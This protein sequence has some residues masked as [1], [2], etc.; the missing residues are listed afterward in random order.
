MSIIGGPLPDLKKLAHQQLIQRSITG[1]TQ[2]MV[3]VK[4]KKQ[5]ISDDI[6][7]T[8]R[9]VFETLTAAQRDAILAAADNSTVDAAQGVR[10][11]PKT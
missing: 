1:T 6:T 9:S 5:W 8:N 11:N 4:I 3:I 10:D 7:D 2:Q